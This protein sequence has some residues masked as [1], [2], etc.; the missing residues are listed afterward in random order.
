VQS[1]LSSGFGA[2]N[3]GE[4]GDAKDGL[5]GNSVEWAV[6]EDVVYG[7]ACVGVGRAKTIVLAAGTS[8]VVAG[9]CSDSE[10]V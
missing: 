3:E 8:C 1:F 5:A 4:G 7:V 10:S 6:E 9:V 2:E